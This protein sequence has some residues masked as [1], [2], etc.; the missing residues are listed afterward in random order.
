[1]LNIEFPI[2]KTI[3]HFS[4]K[5]ACLCMHCFKTNITIEVIHINIFITIPCTFQNNI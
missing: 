3:C 2:S 4:L 1:M 5:N